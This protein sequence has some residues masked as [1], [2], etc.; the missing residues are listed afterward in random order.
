MCFRFRTVVIQ[1]AEPLTYFLMVI[2]YLLG[3]NSVFS[4]EF[5]VPLYQ[6]AGAFLIYTASWLCLMGFL[7][8][9]YDISHQLRRMNRSGESRRY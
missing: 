4:S 1:V 7:A 6:R 5:Q 3:A 9:L 2:G 8:I